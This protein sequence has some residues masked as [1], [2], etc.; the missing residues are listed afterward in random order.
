MT[1]ALLESCSKRNHSNVKFA[2]KSIKEIACIALDKQYKKSLVSLMYLCKM[3]K[4]GF[5]I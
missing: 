4:F 1:K 3:L 2:F 5:L